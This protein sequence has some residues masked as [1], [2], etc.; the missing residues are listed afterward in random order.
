LKTFADFADI[1]YNIRLRPY[2]QVPIFGQFSACR[3]EQG[4]FMESVTF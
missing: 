3:A 4:H 1:G 2:R